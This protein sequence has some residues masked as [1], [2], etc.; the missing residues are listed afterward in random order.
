[1]AVALKWHEQEVG[2]SSQRSLAA[3]R[4][5][6]EQHQAP[7]PCLRSRREWM[8]AWASGWP[9]HCRESGRRGHAFLADDYDIEDH[10]PAQSAEFHQSSPAA[11]G[12]EL[13]KQGDRVS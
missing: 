12:A 11:G 6:P 5:V 1:M 8:P 7:R 4:E 9:G 10:D 2:V 3:K 13:F